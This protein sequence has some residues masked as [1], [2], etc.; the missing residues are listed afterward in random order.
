MSRKALK[1]ALYALCFGLVI[2]IAF[3][4]QISTN[5]NR[6]NYVFGGEAE[7]IEGTGR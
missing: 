5:L 4:G 6:W 2:G 1:I 3:L 7:H